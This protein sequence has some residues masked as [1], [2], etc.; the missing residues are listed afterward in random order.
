MTTDPELDDNFDYNQETRYPHPLPQ[1]G[2]RVFV[3]SVDPDRLDIEREFS[4]P[5]TY[6]DAYMWGGDFLFAS[7]RPRVVQPDDPGGIE[8]MDLDHWMVYP[9]YFLYRHSLELQLKGILGVQ[10]AEG[11]LLP[12]HEPLVHGGHDL[13]KLWKAA[14]P[15]VERS[16]P[17]SL[18]EAFDSFGEMVDEIS[19]HDPKA[20]AGRYPRSKLG[21]KQVQL[22]DSFSGM[23]PIDL[24]VM[25][26]SCVKMLNFITW[27]WSLK[28]DEEWGEREERE[29]R[30]S[31]DDE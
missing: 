11:G 3:K 9:I 6:L 13:S 30:P 26:T 10:Q 4:G 1:K 22:V 20:E 15:W 31:W 24:E 25:R 2:D 27:I 18:R 7:L 5:S 21:R 29:S 17:G 23:R 12:E 16:L 28:D 8:P 14:K 19:K